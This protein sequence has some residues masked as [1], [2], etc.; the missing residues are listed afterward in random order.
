[1]I[2]EEHKQPGE[3]PKHAALA[4]PA[5]G[6]FGRNEWAIVGAPCDDIKALAGELISA[7]VPAK[8]AYVDAS[9]A[10][11]DTM[12][13]MPNAAIS[14]TA[15]N[16]RQELNYQGGLNAFQNRQLLNDSD[17]ILVNGNH[18]KAKKQVVIIDSR[19]K[20][21]LQKRLAQLTD[22]RLFLL[23]NGE[24]DLFDFI[25]EAIP[26]WQQ[27]P[28]YD[29][30]ETQR[31][32]S[33]FKDTL[34]QSIPVLNGLVLAGGKS[35]RMGQ[36]KGAINWYQKEQRYHMADLLKNYV[37]EVY[38]S[39]RAEQQQAV[40]PA[41][42][43]LTDTFTGLGPFGAI[44]SAFRE[45]PERA[46]LVVACDLPLLDKTTL[47]FLTAHRDTSAVATTFESPH[48]GFP[49]PLITIWEPK[50]YPVLLSFLAQGYSCPRK[51][52]INSD[53][54]IIQPPQST[55]LMNVNTPQELE[56]AKALL[57]QK[58]ITA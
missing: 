18:H 23:A 39:C 15:H 24:T 28:V 38:I 41:Y 8:V 51:V 29:L 27:I 6:N 11:E 47:D 57:Q 4:R 7:I 20:A 3:K 53:T 56:Q 42:A 40:D 22:V 17:M 2:S 9:H 19:K 49:E 1:M 45:Q 44:L 43:T 52:L 14:Y 35:E 30:N 16:N 10:D 34:R 55:A 5:L 48:D 21:S 46:W 33:F 36:D 26:N 13:S 25:K 50:S 58:T 12:I 54:Q 31:I 37:D 32:I